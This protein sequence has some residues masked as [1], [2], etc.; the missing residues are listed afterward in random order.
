[1]R[2]NELASYWTMDIED[3]NQTRL[4][5]SIPFLLGDY[6]ASNILEQYAYLEIGSAYIVSMSNSTLECPDDNTLGTDFILV[7]DD[8][9]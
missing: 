5:S 6:P 9:A 8:N 1:M 4:V 2:Y 7:W 3:Q